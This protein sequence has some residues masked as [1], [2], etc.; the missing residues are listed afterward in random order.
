MPALFMIAQIENLLFITGGKNVFVRE[1]KRE[2]YGSEGAVAMLVV[3]VDRNWAKQ[4][5][6]HGKSPFFPLSTIN[7]LFFL[8]LLLFS[9]ILSRSRR[10]KLLSRVRFHI[11]HL[12]LLSEHLFHSPLQVPHSSSSSSSPKGQ[13]RTDR[14]PFPLPPPYHTHTVHTYSSR[15]PLHSSHLVRTCTYVGKWETLFV[16]SLS[17]FSPEEE[18]ERGP[19][20][21]LA[22][23]C[24][25][26]CLV[27]KR[28]TT[29]YPTNQPTNPLACHTRKEKKEKKRKRGRQP[30][31]CQKRREEEEEEEWSDRTD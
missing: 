19:P 6:D 31:K 18:E 24:L 2:F 29:R 12:V 26:V 28:D 14:R 30:G 13:H 9:T 21:T 20:P 10:R 3:V 4:A 8:L 25:S 16:C 27:E 5:T 23:T 1:R 15:V 11:G 17:R 7:A 22:G